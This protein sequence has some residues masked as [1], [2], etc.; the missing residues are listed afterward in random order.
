MKTK[1]KDI[2]NE[3]KQYAQKVENKIDMTEVLRTSMSK[4]SFREENLKSN[5]DPEKEIKKLR[6]TI[7]DLKVSCCH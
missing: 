1:I 3:I 5:L 4:M 7:V 6:K 2:D